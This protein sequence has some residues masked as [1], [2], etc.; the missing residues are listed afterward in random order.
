MDQAEQSLDQATLH[1]LHLEEIED[2]CR[3][4][5]HEGGPTPRDILKALNE[6]SKDLVAL[7][8]VEVL[9]SERDQVRDDV[10]SMGLELE[11]LGRRPSGD[12]WVALD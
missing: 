1:E 2:R 11:E 6:G 5:S 8:L 7:N 4:K 10:E 3:K 12:D 9:W